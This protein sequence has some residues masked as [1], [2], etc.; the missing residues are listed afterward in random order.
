MEVKVLTLEGKIFDGE[1]TKVILPA[2]EGEMTLLP[3]HI[4]IVTALQTGKLIIH[5]AT[6]EPFST[7]I[8]SGICCFSNN[9]ASIILDR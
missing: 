3:H 6:K 9:C 8:N 1:A 4:S 2:V 7:E 5:R